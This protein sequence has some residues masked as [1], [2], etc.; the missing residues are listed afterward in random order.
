MPEFLVADWRRSLQLIHMEVKPTV[1]TRILREMSVLH[2]CN[3]SYIVGF[4]GSF[5]LDGD[6][7][8]FMEYMVRVCV[9][10]FVS[11]VMVPSFS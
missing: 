5:F 11:L 1:A 10:R 9:C 6:I 8:I 2:D 7:S 4:Y 3:S